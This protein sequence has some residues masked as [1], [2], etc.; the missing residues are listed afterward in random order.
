MARTFSGK[1]PKRLG[2]TVKTFLSYLG[3]HKF[4]LLAVGVLVAVSATANLLGTYM[5][6]PVVNA[7]VFSR[8]KHGADKIARDLT[9]QGIP[10]AAIHGN[11]SQ[12]ARQQALADFKSGAIRCL[13]ATD[14]AARGLDIEELSHVFNYNLPDV[15][16]TY[17]HRIGRTGRAKRHGVAVSMIADYPAKM[18]IDNIAKCTA[19]TIIPAQMDENGVLSELKEG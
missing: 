8:T 12:T 6:R 2:Y 4:L 9:K 15:P 3:R 11:K 18:R 13:V 19:N 17:V 16:E 1:K 5:I 10:A 7:L 14:I